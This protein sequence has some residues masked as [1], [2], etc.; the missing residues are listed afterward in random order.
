M[1]KSARL[2]DLSPLECVAPVITRVVS[3][4]PFL[5][6]RH[7][8]GEPLFVSREST[9]GVLTGVACR[10]L[11]E[12]VRDELCALGI[13]LD[14]QNLVT[15]LDQL[16]REEEADFPASSDDRVHATEPPCLRRPQSAL[17]KRR[18]RQ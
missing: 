13:V 7:A 18:S 17:G 4:E 5:K 6:P 11:P 8:I 3:F 10:N 2:M 16:T 9:Q 15:L 14:D 1:P 12:L